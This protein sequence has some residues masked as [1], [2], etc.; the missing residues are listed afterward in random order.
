[1]TRKTIIKLL[2]SLAAL[3][4]LVLLVRTFV[5]DGSIGGRIAVVDIIGTITKSDK[6]I[7]LIHQYRDN[8]SVKAIVVRIDSPGGSV[9][10]VQE[11]YSELKKLDKPVV[12]SLG[13]TAASGGYYIASAADEIFANPGTLTGSIG[14]IMQFVKMKALFDKVGVNQQTV[15]SGEFK[16]TGSPVRDLTPE[17]KELLQATIDDV[18]SQ[19]IDAIF[20]T[21]KDRLTRSEVQALADGR[22]FSGNQALEYKLVDRLGNLP[23]AVAHAAEL[24]GI[25]GKPRIT[26]VKHEPSLLERI[27]GISGTHALEDFF[28]G[29]G[30]LFRYELSFAE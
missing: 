2:V 15:K 6:V 20:D 17:E 28:D 12:A 10:P 13:G 25:E 26:R 22:I 19:F 5:G 30:V 4:I 24:A 21:R 8:G 29:T 23:D 3:V 1:M 18:H 11:I 7:E 14:V 16:D 9:A 27:I